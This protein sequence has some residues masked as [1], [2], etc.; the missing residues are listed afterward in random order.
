MVDVCRRVGVVVGADDRRVERRPA[1]GR[2]TSAQSVRLPR[3][4]LHVDHR[5]RRLD[6]VT[7]RR[8]ASPRRPTPS[9]RQPRLRTARNFHVLPRGESLYSTGSI[10]FGYYRAPPC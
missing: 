7:G 4:S 1:A 2:A 5:R 6:R 8:R 3:Q 9:R 10:C